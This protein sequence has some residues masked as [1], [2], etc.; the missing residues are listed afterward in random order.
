MR[1]WMLPAGGMCRNH[2]LGEHRELHMLIGSIRKGISLEGYVLNGLVDPGMI[3]K[4]HEE[5]CDELAARRYLHKSPITPEDLRLLEGLK[6]NPIPLRAS[7]HSL[8]R[9]CA[10]CKTLSYEWVGKYGCMCQKCEALR[11]VLQ[12]LM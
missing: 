6:S 8:F 7:Y 5:L 10:T 11:G 4:R 1:M 2:L 9:R 3:Y 12:E